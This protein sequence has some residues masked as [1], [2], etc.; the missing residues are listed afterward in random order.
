MDEQ[1]ERQV[2]L[3]LREGRADAWR[4]FYE[5]FAERVWRCAAR[6]MGP[7]EDDVADVVQETFMAA[8]R[9]ARSYDPQRGSLW[10]WLWAIGRRQVALHYR[11][12]ARLDRLQQAAEWLAADGSVGRWLEG[13]QDTPADALAASE[14]AALVRATL[15]ELPSEYESLLSARYLDGEP[16]ERIAARERTSEVAVRSK[17]ARARQAFRQSF[18]RYAVPAGPPAGTRHDHPGR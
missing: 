13:K 5:A 3:G 10:T 17:L 14:L 2:S 1:Q 8:A 6:L 16:V 9:S 15:T 4:T 11:K 12:R 7:P 18:G